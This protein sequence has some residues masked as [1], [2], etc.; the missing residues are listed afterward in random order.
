M[1]KLIKGFLMTGFAFAVFVVPS[2]AQDAKKAANAYR[3]TYYGEGAFTR[4]AEDDDLLTEEDWINNRSAVEEKYGGDFRWNK[5]MKF[6]AD[7]DGA[8]NR[9]EARAYRDAETQRIRTEWRERHPDDQ[10]KYREFL[11]NHPNDVAFLKNHPGV[12][13]Q[14]LS[15]KEYL[16]DHPRVVKSLY[17]DKKWLSNHPD[18]AGEIFKQRKFLNNHP[19]FT[20][21]LY[22]NREWL[23]EH[24]S[25]AKE[26][27]KNREF[28]NQHPEFRQ[29]LK[30]HNE[31]LRNHPRATKRAY[32]KAK[33]RPE[34]AKKIYRTGKNHPRA[35]KWAAKHPKK[36]KKCLRDRRHQ[37]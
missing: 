17:S 30:R 16:K 24:P 35:G 19:E 18:V 26:A 21:E 14:I 25:V 10:K 29:D 13:R 4:L 28:L 15:N 8:L 7:G 22:K 33:Q 20:K 6:D 27:Y 23:N 32:Q 11:K 1:K 37:R 9:D 5:A 12:A 34:A 36:A 3:N 2:Y 31:Y